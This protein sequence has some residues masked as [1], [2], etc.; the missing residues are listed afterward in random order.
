VIGSPNPPSMTKLRVLVVDDSTVFRRSL[1]DALSA[2]PEIEVVGTAG[3]GEEALQTA[4]SLKPHVITLDLE[5]PRMDGFTFLRILVARQPTAVVVCSSHASRENVFKALELG[6]VEFVVKPSAHRP[7]E[8]SLKD[9]IIAKVLLTRHLRTVG[10]RMRPPMPSVGEREAESAPRILPSDPPEAGA[11]PKVRFVIAVASSTGGPIALLDIASRLP[12]R[13]PGALLI[14]QHMPESFTRTFA[15][16]L[17]R[18]GPIRFVEVDAP[19]A[20]EER[21]GYVSPGNQC[22]VVAPRSGSELG[23]A[24]RPA[25]NERYVPSGDLLMK[26]A[27]EH[28]GPRVVGIVLTGM[29]DDGLAGARAVRDAGGIVVAES[30]QS[31]VVYGMP[32]AV[33][34][35]GLANHVMSLAEISAFL[36]GL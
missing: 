32:G 3:N 35:A 24:L 10:T 26:T 5:M 6:A 19:E 9:E 22:L 21:R 28:A 8:S 11:R 16:R 30:E 1:V 20:L 4:L 13:F 12:E 23:V 36:G 2:H 25:G 7:A 34:R 27:A 33:V 15:E 14:A 17:D 18:K 31:A 29:G